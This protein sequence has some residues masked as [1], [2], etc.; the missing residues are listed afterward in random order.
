[1][2]AW[3]YAHLLFLKT[4]TTVTNYQ[5]LPKRIVINQL[6]FLSVKT[7]QV[8]LSLAAPQF[9]LSDWNWL[10]EEGNSGHIHI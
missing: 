8:L 9:S 6:L 2:H 7:S 3:I 5:S 4:E 10:W 1:M